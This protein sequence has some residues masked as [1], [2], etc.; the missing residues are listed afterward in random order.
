MKSHLNLFFAGTTEDYTIL[1]GGVFRQIR[2]LKAWFRILLPSFEPTG[3][4]AVLAW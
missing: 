1:F 2:M 3:L 4:N